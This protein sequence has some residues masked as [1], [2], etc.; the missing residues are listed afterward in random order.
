MEVIT[1]VKVVII[2]V[3]IIIM[4]VTVD[5]EEV[6]TGED[7]V[8]WGCYQ[9]RL[10]RQRD[11]DLDRLEGRVDYYY[12]RFQRLDRPRHRLRHRV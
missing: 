8:G 5:A 2:M 1:I 6:N 11:R 4:V 7:Q 12:R 10:G 9:G 3:V